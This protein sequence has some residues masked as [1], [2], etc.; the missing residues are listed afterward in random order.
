MGLDASQID[1][2]FISHEHGDHMGRLGAVLKMNSDIKVVVPETFSNLF[3]D[4]AA[5][6]GSISK[7]I[8][9]PV[10]VCKGLCSTGINGVAIPEQ[11]MVLNSGKGLV[12]ITGC[13]HPGIINILE[14]V[15]KDFG[16]EIYMVVGG[17]HL[18]N[19]SEKEINEIIYGMRQLGVKKCGATHCTR[20]HQIEWFRS[21]FGENFVELGTGNVITIL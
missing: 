14:Q 1:E 21:S 7:L 5:K 11:S 9:D 10:Q 18:M 3:F 4:I 12:V 20:D 2:V 13:A 19:K 6:N 17:F 15:K 8:R 16:K